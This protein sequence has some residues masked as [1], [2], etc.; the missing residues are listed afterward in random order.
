MVALCDCADPNLSC[1][2]MLA[3]AGTNMAFTLPCMLSFS[4]SF[5][6]ICQSLASVFMGVCM[7]TASLAVLNCF[8]HGETHIGCVK[9]RAWHCLFFK[10]AG[11]HLLC[12]SVCVLCV[13]VCVCMCVWGTWF[14]GAH[15]YSQ[16]MYTV[17]PVCLLPCMAL[18]CTVWHCTA[19][20]SAALYC[21]IFHC[22][23][24]LCI[25]LYTA[26]VNGF[27]SM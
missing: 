13:S 5:A 1:M 3:M 18:H 4:M 12:V 24:L 11:F 27:A 7:L 10:L 8:R 25:E 2:D 26:H 20:L 17:L 14:T 15:A 23:M 22:C 16:P 9:Y 19:P 6:Y 21:T